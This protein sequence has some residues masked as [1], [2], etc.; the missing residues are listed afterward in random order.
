MN[1]YLLGI[2]RWRSR[3]TNWTYSDVRGTFDNEAVGETV[4][5]NG[6]TLLVQVDLLFRQKVSNSA[7][8]TKSIKEKNSQNMIWNYSEL[9]SVT[10]SY[11]YISHICYVNMNYNEIIDWFITNNKAAKKMPTRTSV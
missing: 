7:A 2:F 3:R 8:G 1:T 10:W 11:N 9:N 6:A 4:K 5:A